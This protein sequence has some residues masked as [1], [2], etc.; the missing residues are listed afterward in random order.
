MRGLMLTVALL[1]AGVTGCV[2]KRTQPAQVQPRK[3]LCHRATGKIT[4]DGKL[5]EPAW[6]AAEVI[7]DFRI[8]GTGARPKFL[9]SVRLLWDDEYLYV[10]ADMEDFDVNATHKEH[11]S[12]LWDDDVIE[13]FLKPREDRNF[14]YEF[15]VNPLATTLNLL[16]GRRGAG[17]FDRWRTWESGMKAAVTIQGTLNDWTDKDAGWCAEFAIPLKAF[18]STGPR[19]QLGDRWRFALCRYEYSVYIQDGPELSSSARLPEVN[20]HKYEA[21]DYLEFAE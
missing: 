14:Y 2:A 6:Q 1:S 13:L 7:E 16:I 3:F 18:E 12:Q 19:P 20:F 5:N 8:P 15:Q 4:I 17:T 10:G 11:N 9:T 21:Y